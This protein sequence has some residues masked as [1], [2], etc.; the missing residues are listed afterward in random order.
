MTTLLHYL[1]EYF[2]DAAN[3]SGASGIPTRLA[4]HFGYTLLAFVISVLL[5]LPIGLW[6]GHTGRGGVLVSL[7]ANAARALPTYGLLVLLVVLYGIG[8][9]PVMVPLVALAIPPILLNSYEGIRGVDP[10]LTDAARGMGMTSSQILLRAQLP[11]ALPLILVGLRTAAVQ[12]V[13]TATIAAA[14]SFGGVG[15]PIV[16]GLA[17]S[18]YALVVGGAALA[19]ICS[20]VILALFAVLGQVLVSPGV[21]A[22]RD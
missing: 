3:W 12:I 9:V 4:Q 1:A 22:S 7:T 5:A 13:A 8:L 16:D 21:R 18:D 14:V 19:G 11:V 6:T 20:L 15:R 17:R 10:A 2:G